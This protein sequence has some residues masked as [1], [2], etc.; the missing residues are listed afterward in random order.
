VEPLP[1]PEQQLPGHVE[2]SH[3]H[4]PPVQC[5]S[6][7]QDVQAAPPAP[8][9]EEV[10]PGRQVLPEQQPDGQELALHTQVP[11]EGLQVWPEPQ[12]V[13]EPPLMPQLAAVGGEMQVVP[14]QQPVEQDEGVQSQLPETQ[15]CST[16]QTA[17]SAP[18]VP[19]WLSLL[20]VWQ[21]PP[22]QQP[23]QQLPP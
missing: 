10:L 11:V 8:H 22:S 15:S 6:P 19:Q 16:P 17:Q 23:V 13:Q 5:V 9:A 4:W 14:E 1:D 20:V 18:P 3:R 21:V 7:V 2:L 12:A